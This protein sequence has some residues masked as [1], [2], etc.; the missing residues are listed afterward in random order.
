MQFQLAAISLV[1]GLLSSQRMHELNATVR[2]FF[3]HK[4]VNPL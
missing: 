1:T 3:G 2:Y 4:M